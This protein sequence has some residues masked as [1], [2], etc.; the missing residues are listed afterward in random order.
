MLSGAKPTVSWK[1]TFTLSADYPHA[2]VN[3]L[4]TYQSLSNTNIKVNCKSKDNFS[5]CYMI[6]DDDIIQRENG[7]LSRVDSSEKWAH[8]QDEEI[9]D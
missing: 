4:Q 8:F 2:L 1:K 3:I 5:N 6:M 9:R 7:G